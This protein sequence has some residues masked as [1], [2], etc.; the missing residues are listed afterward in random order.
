RVGHCGMV[1]DLAHLGARR[2]QLV[3]M[4]TPPCRIFAIAIAAHLRTIEDAFDSSAQSTRG[5]RLC[6]PNWFQHLESQR[7]VAR[8][9]W[10]IADDWLRISG[11][12]RLPLRGVLRIT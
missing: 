6:P 1:L 12:R 8:L 2:Q 5:L 10:K 7:G 3:H 9:D 4:T 11:D